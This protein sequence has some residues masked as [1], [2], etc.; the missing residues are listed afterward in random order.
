MITRYTYILVLCFTLIVL[1]GVGCNSESKIN[2][3]ESTLIKN[4]EDSNSLNINENSKQEQV[5]KGEEINDDKKEN[6]DEIDEIIDPRIKPVIQGIE[7]DE[8]GLREECIINGDCN[9]GY[10]CIDGICNEPI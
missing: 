6:S 9:D 4:I 3:S 7:R 8:Y 2:N 5:I 1:A 10:I